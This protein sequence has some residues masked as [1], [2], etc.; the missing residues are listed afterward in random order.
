VFIA[1]EDAEAKAT[2]T[3]LA[4]DGGLRPIDAG[5]LRRARELEAPGELA[6]ETKAPPGSNQ[7]PPGAQL[8]V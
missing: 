3:Q 5:P 6:P 1:S 8:R 4:S 7:Q 2:V